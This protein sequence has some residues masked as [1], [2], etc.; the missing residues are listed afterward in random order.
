MKWSEIAWKR[1]EGV[2]HA[3]LQLPFVKELTE[4]T[5]SHERFIFYIRQDACYLENYSKVLAHIASRLPQKQWREDFLRFASEGIMVENALHASFAEITASDIQPT[6]TCLLYNSYEAAKGL[7]QVEIEAAAIL[8]C[9]WIY[10]LVGK[11]IHKHSNPD[12]PYARWIDTYAD[13]SFALST[14][15]AIEICDELAANATE[16]V[17]HEM[18]EAF[19]MA[20]KMEWMF[21]ESAYN[22]EQWKI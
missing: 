18:T 14:A 8:P 17:C 11:E 9:F 15:R 5:L 2:Y 16:A 21:W 4:G 12:N 3:I 1:A 22:L 7:E 6:P 10:M 20:T 19:L 13:E